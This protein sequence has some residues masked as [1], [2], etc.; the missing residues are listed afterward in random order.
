V[1]ALARR[2]T[3]EAIKTLATIM[4]D[5]S[6]TPAV[7][8]AAANALLDRGHGRPPQAIETSHGTTLVVMTG[9][10]RAPDQP[11]LITDVT[12][13]TDVPNG[14]GDDADAVH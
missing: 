11:L 3:K 7:R 12:D 13:V 14:T 5:E 6:Y 1:Q 10:S 9:I 8:V 4:R 2:Y